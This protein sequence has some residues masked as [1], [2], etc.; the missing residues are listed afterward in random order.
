MNKKLKSNVK[1]GKNSI[2][3]PNLMKTTCPVSASGHVDSRPIA[4]DQSFVTLRNF[5]EH[6][7]I[8]RIGAKLKKRTKVFRKAS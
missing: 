6:Q 1:V 8:K 2:G 3:K 5:W 7:T 4:V